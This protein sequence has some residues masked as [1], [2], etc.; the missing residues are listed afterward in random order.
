M[1]KRGMGWLG[2]VFVL[3][4]GL[5]AL[6]CGSSAQATAT[7]TKTPV[8]TYTPTVVA[9]VPVVV[10]ATATPEPP[11][12]TPVAVEAWVIPVNQS[13]DRARV[14][15]TLVDVSF[16]PGDAPEA[17]ELRQRER[18]ANAQVVGALQVVV[19]NNR[20]EKI[21]VF[22]DQ[23]VVVV[24]NEQIEFFAGDDLG[25]EMFQGVRKHGDVLFA[26]NNISY[27]VLSGLS[28]I[29]EVDAPVIMEPFTILTDEGYLFQ[30]TI[31]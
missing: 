6:A 19:E 3:V 23:G 7:P 28:L 26:L 14:V 20:D 13:I 17:Q 4:W 30:L 25:G 24:G 1:R 8:L 15:I 31:P 2:I 27:E 16:W 11:M 5:P 9:A 29:Y 22:A 18:Y 12:A 21:V 10:E